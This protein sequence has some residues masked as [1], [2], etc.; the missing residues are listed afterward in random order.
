MIPVIKRQT[1]V[2]PFFVTRVG[3][4]YK[5]EEIT[6]L[7]GFEEFQIMQVVSG[8]G[9][10]ECA[11]KTYS[12]KVNDVVLFYPD[13][14]HKYY[15]IDGQD[16]I[17]NWVCFNGN[18]CENVLNE[19]VNDG[20]AVI[21]KIKSSK[22][23]LDFESLADALKIDSVY[24]HLQASGIL[25]NMFIKLVA[26]ACD[27]YEDN[28]LS[29]QLQPV[30]DYMWANLPNDI[31]IEELSAVIGVSVS[32]LCRM[33]KSVYG[34]SPIKHLIMLRMLTAKNLLLMNSQRTISE[35]SIECGYKDTSYF[36]AEFK[37]YF[38][39]TPGSLKK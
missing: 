13:I 31:I 19:I 11:G 16:W 3:I 37:K 36:C 7:N 23:Y 4:F 34:T 30:I 29:I 21:K 27:L 32:Y 1:E 5:V 38:N 25:Y 20:H 2:M 35:I 6:R 14:P 39:M 26:Y 9:V 24:A 8:E 10:F 15:P 28:N 17:L 18:G 22:L 12:I 33:F